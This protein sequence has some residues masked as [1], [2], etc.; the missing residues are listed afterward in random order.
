MTGPVTGPYFVDLYPG[1]GGTDGPIS[2]QRRWY[3]QRKP[4]NLPLP[5]VSYRREVVYSNT[6]VAYYATPT[7]SVDDFGWAYSKAYSKFIDRMSSAS[8]WAV[9]LAERG[10]TL[11]SLVQ[12]ANLLTRF[13]RKLRHGDLVGAARSLHLGDKPPRGAKGWAKNF[14]DAW[15]SYHFGWEPLVK[16]IGNAIETLQGPIP[17]CVV[18]ASSVF[19]RKYRIGTGIPYSKVGTIETSVKLGARCRVTNPS[20]Y[21]ANQ[22]GFVN[23]AVVAW[24]LVPFSFVVD[25]VGNVGQFLSSFTDF[26]GVSL[27]GAF[28]TYFQTIKEREFWPPPTNVIGLL[29]H[30]QTRYLERVE[31]VSQPSLVV[32][33]YQG[34]SV[35]RGA[36]AIS[37]LLQQLR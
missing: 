13:T 15:L 9:N 37:L 5:H 24:E 1:P 23:P 3:R 28:T 34:T 7:Y 8:N 2:I 16:D 30:Y 25:W 14:G 33:P 36:T 18:H 21:L 35:V 4:Y 17:S 20:L 27:E 29:H 26:A 10:Q 32:P 11:N 12:S 6:N 31:G 19:R 22:L